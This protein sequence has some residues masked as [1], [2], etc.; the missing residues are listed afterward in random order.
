MEK[1]RGWI[2]DVKSPGKNPLPKQIMPG[3]E[4]LL[5]MFQVL[6]ANSQLF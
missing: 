4:Q 3:G 2:V 1:R 5:L 6:M